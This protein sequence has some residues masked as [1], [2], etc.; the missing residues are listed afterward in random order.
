MALQEGERLRVEGVL[1]GRNACSFQFGFQLGQDFLLQ[2]GPA[3]KGRRQ[4][5]S[6]PRQRLFNAEKVSASKPR[7]KIHTV[8]RA[9]GPA[10]GYGVS[11]KTSVHTPFTVRRGPVIR[12]PMPVTGVVFRQ[13]R[14]HTR[15]PAERR[16]SRGQRTV[17]PN[18]IRERNTKNFTETHRG[19]LEPRRAHTLAGRKNHTLLG[20]RESTLPSTGYFK[21][22]AGK[23]Y[24][25]RR[26]IRVKGYEWRTGI[27]GATNGTLAGTGIR[28]RKR[29]SSSRKETSPGSWLAVFPG[30]PAKTRGYGKRQEARRAVRRKTVGRETPPQVTLGRRSSPMPGLC[31][32]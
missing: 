32:P 7:Q 9:R 10:A 18:G 11:P 3:L 6:L 15:A 31:C 8:Q 12:E 1:Q 29:W 16:A 24:R 13:Q 14:L 19:R 2:R 23:R 26:G 4:A 25:T 5:V 17:S 20:D 22:P 27:R 21:Q 28:E 30:Q